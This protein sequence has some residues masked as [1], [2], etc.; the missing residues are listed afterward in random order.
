MNSVKHSGSTLTS[1]LAMQ[2]ITD[3]KMKSGV[4]TEIRQGNSF[5]NA[6]YRHNSHIIIP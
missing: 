2:Y 4:T 1:L 3:M 5:F 6:V